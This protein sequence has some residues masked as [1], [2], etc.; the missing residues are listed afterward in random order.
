MTAAQKSPRIYVQNHKD[1]QVMDLL[2]HNGQMEVQ[3]INLPW[4]GSSLWVC[5]HKRKKLMDKDKNSTNWA[6]FPIILLK[7]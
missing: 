4:Q 2:D 7:L 1:L 5:V 3:M 6:V